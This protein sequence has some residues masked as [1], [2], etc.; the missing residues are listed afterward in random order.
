METFVEKMHQTVGDL[1]NKSVIR[2]ALYVFI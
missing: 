1:Q 2:L